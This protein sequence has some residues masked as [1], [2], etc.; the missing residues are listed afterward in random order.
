MVILWHTAYCPYKCSIRE[1]HPRRMFTDLG[2]RS[3][4]DEVL[5][6]EQQHFTVSMQLR[7]TNKPWAKLKL[8]HTCAPYTSHYAKMW[9]TSGQQVINM[10]NTGSEVA[11]AR[12]QE[13]T[14]SLHTDS[15]HSHSIADHI[16]VRPENFILDGVSAWTCISEDALSA[17]GGSSTA[18]EN[19]LQAKCR[20]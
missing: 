2:P 18:Q 3:P 12:E 13:F 19:V 16:H 9:S 8:S 17:N 20:C 14:L 5:P 7:V 4:P 1:K 11:K 6:N 10:H 15:L